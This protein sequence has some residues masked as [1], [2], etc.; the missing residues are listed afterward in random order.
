MVADL[1]GDGR[2]DVVSG[3]GDFVLLGNGDGTF[4][5]PFQLGAGGS[6]IAVGDLN[7]DGR[8][9]LAVGG[10]AVLLNITPAIKT[11]T[12]TTLNSS[13]NPSA[14][15]ESTTF[16]SNDTSMRHTNWNSDIR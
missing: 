13:Q 1:N 5:S 9:D 8:P 12:T 2:P 16:R 7:G 14:Y 4:Q 6:G 11:S 3:I 10:V 15:G